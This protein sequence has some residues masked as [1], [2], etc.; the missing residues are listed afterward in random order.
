[1]KESSLY[2]KGMKIL[3]Y[4]EKKSEEEGTGWFRGGEDIEYYR[5]GLFRLYK[6]KKCFSS[7][8]F[9]YK[10]EYDDDYVYFANNIPYTYTDLN[11]ELNEFEKNE[12]KYKYEIN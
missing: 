2:N 6:E 10:F 3:I 1:M 9:S 12:K 8:T 4:S 5:N 11:K 7:L